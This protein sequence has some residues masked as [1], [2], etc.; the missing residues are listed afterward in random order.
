VSLES[1]ARV[2]HGQDEASDEDED[3]PDGQQL[4]EVGDV[5][6]VHFEE[7]LESAA[8]NWCAFSFGVPDLKL[9]FCY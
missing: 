9:V 8:E 4:L 5:P 1:D 2:G 6:V 7:M 3:E